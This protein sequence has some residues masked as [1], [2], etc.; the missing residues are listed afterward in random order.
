MKLPLSRKAGSDTTN[1]KIFRAAS[2]VGA[3]SIAGKG[4]S[5]INELVISQTFGRSDDVDAFLIAF[6]LPVFVLNI[7][8][9]ALA[10]VLVPV[11]A[12]SQQ[13]QGRESAQRLLSG[14]ALLSCAALLATTILLG[15]L[16]PFYLPLLG[17]GFSP[18]KLTLTWKLLF[19]LLPW[20]VFRGVA[21]LS[22]SFLNALEKFVF[23]AVVPLITPVVTICLVVFEARRWGIFTLVFGLVAGGAIEW[24]LLLRLL[25]AQGLHF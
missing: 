5:I 14:I 25:R 19:L 1:S 22:A 15:L 12:D 9:S 13:T 20:I 6:L 24:A 7:G 3:L 21:N 10:Y 11:F 23:P 2:I 18:S 17:R 8:M 4:A 16:A